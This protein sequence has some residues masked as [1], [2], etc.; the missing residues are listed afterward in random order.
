MKEDEGLDFPI[1]VTYNRPLMGFDIG[2]KLR[3]LNAADH[4]E[5]DRTDNRT[6]NRTD[7]AKL[8]VLN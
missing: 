4:R 6:D 7:I 1:S 5:A 8:T 3:W 2:P